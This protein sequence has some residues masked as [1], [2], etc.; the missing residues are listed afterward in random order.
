MS[1]VAEKICRQVEFYFSDVNI[2]KDV[3]LKSKMAEDSDGFVPFDVLLTFNRLNALTKD[4]QVIADALK[5]SGKLVL[6]EDGLAVRRKDPLPE[7]VQTDEQTVYVKPIPG[8][9]SLEDL[10]AFFSKYGTVLAVWRR[11]FQGSKDAAPES[12]LKPSVFVVFGSKDEAERFQAAPPEMDGVQ[13]TA[14]MKTAYLEEKA[15]EMAARNKGRK[16]PGESGA[17]ASEAPKTPAMPKDSSYRL[18]GC[19]A[20]ERFS[21]VKG[22][23]PA[24]E[25]RG[26]RYV[27]MPTKEEALIIFQD[28]ETAK[29]MVES[30]TKRAP[31][32]NGKQPEVS[33]IEGD[34]EAELITNV[35]KEI[36]DRAAQHGGR[37]SGG[38]GRGRGGR[39]G[40][41]P[42]S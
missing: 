18:A 10:T 34:A 4:V 19:G 8:T 41:R 28:A 11:Y 2:A 35:E 7:S 22:L 3:F 33:K 42:R 26:V 27:F 13:L 9:T 36:S 15:A 17:A 12:R 31:T 21:D 37:G 29:T 30:L 38:R 6:R 39:G 24:E 25:Q 23:W 14:Q 5:N 1:S 40:K 20:I 32:L 16:R